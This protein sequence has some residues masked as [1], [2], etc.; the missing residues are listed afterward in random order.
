MSVSSPF[1]TPSVDVAA[2]QVPSLAQTPL[3]QSAPFTHLPEAATLPCPFPAPFA[4]PDVELLPVTLNP[5]NVVQAD[6]A[7]ARAARSG[8]RSFM[9]FLHRTLDLVLGNPRL[10]RYPLFACVLGPP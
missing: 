9:R 5:S 10:S 4:P 2:V 6:E 3:V 1:F 8:T 7:N